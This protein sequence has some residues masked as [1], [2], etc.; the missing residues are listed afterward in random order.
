MHIEISKE[1][2]SQI[3]LQTAAS[4]HGRSHISVR[5]TSHGMH[6]LIVRIYKKYRS[7]I[8]VRPGTE[9]V[10][11]APTAE[12]CVYNPVDLC[13]VMRSRTCWVVSPTYTKHFNKTNTKEESQVK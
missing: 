4:V 10:T 7:T 5:H 13:M 2:Q 11:N 12:K 6:S 9:Y 1:V 8:T 3:Q